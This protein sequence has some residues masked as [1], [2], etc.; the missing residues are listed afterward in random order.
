MRPH[1]DKARAI[2]NEMHSSSLSQVRI[3]FTESEKNKTPLADQCSCSNSQWQHLFQTLLRAV[4]L[5][6]VSKDPKS[7]VQKQG[8]ATERGWQRGSASAGR[9]RSKM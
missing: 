6:L 1:C 5:A 8:K 3:F 2:K 7:E 4:N 9:R